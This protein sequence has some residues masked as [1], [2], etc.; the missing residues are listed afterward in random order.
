MKIVIVCGVVNVV[1]KIDEGLKSVG[2]GSI[3][4][5]IVDKG[6]KMEVVLFKFVEMILLMIKI[7]KIL[8]DMLKFYVLLFVGL[9]GSIGM[10]MFVKKVSVVFMVW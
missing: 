8:Y 10:L 9:V 5:I 4:E 2:F 6:V 3:S 7:V 1:I